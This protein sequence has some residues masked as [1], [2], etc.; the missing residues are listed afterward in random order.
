MRAMLR[1]SEGV[2]MRYGVLPALVLALLVAAWHAHAARSSDFAAVK[3]ASIV[4]VPLGKGDVLDIDGA[5]SDVLVADPG[6]IDV[7]AL[8]SGRIYMVGLQVG[9]TNIL[10]VDANGDVIKRFD[11]HVRYD[12]K[13]IQSLV[14]SFFP[15][16]DIEIGAI[17]DQIFLRGEVATPDVASEVVKIV[18][19]YVSDIMDEDFDDPDEIFVNMLKVRSGQQVMLRVK[20]MEVSRSMLRELGIETRLN[21][22]NELSTS[23]IF[24]QLPASN[25]LGS[26]LEEIGF[27][28]TD[29]LAGAGLTGD[30]VF[31]GRSVLD[32]GIDGIGLIENTLNALEENGLVNILAEPNLTAVSGE[33]AGFLAGG[34]FPVPAGRDETGNLV[35]NFRQFGVSLNFRP[36]VISEKRI[37]LRMNTEV[38]SLDFDSSVTLQGVDVPGLDLRRAST[39]VEMPSGASLMIAGILRSESAKGMTGLPGVHKTPILGDLISSNSF[40]RDESELVVLVTPYLV[41]PF[42]EKQ[43]A[44]DVPEELTRP[45]ATAFAENI[46]RTYGDRAPDMFDEK[47]QYGYLLQ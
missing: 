28:T 32:S 11:V 37:S 24:G 45:L 34:E 13:A 9:D 18:A 27:L 44:E 7:T 12:L 25:V 41:E 16:D 5:V 39:V 30:P 40:R 19:H 43:Y 21:D 10:A 46:R 17:H 23:L 14:D 38:S 29:T 22:L 47:M 26:S 42:A 31:T 36:I 33:E 15:D 4:Q 35:I 6:I 3:G 1:V 2:Y 8:Q 20:I